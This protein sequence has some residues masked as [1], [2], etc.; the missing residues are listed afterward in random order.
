MHAKLD[1]V[2]K[3]NP[4]K[5]RC[6]Y[7]RSTEGR[8]RTEKSNLRFP[9]PACLRGKERC[10]HPRRQPAGSAPAP[11][12]AGQR[13]AGKGR[14]GPRRPALT[15]AV[16]RPAPGN[17]SRSTSN[18]RWSLFF[19]F[20]LIFFFIFFPLFPPPIPSPSR[21]AATLERGRIKRE[22]RA[23]LRRAPLPRG[24]PS[25]PG[26]APHLRCHEGEVHG[27]AAGALGGAGGGAEAAA[28]AAAAAGGGRGAGARRGHRLP[29]QRRARPRHRHRYQFQLRRLPA[30]P[31]PALPGAARP[32]VP[33]GGG[34]GDPAPARGW[35]WVRPRGGGRRR[36]RGATASRRPTA[37]VGR[38]F[39][40]PPR[41][42]AP[43]RPTSPSG[44]T[45]AWDQ[46]R[47]V[48]SLSWNEAFPFPEAN[49]PQKS[50]AAPASRSVSRWRWARLDARTEP[51][52]GSGR[53]SPWS[54]HAGRELMMGE[55]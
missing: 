8:K 25:R 14:A 12:T 7:K 44:D 43:S 3:D 40:P 51:G 41:H 49:R 48:A 38:L 31:G 45:V 16:P 37:P 26:A 34:G 17:F 52:R 15:G 33:P 6:T 55:G 11:A 50:F 24:H 10:C 35:A 27:A 53:G 46:P 39:P 4:L 9:F 28:A 47:T 19:L 5:H 20:F 23:M 32:A 30:R 2:C 21:T 22:T 18:S 42:R 13:G 1:S 54:N 36:G 29:Q